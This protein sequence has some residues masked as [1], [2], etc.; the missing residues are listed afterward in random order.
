M[1]KEAH[2]DGKAHVEKPF[3]REH[4][5]VGATRGAGA[6]PIFATS[7]GGALSSAGGAI[8]QA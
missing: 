7:G 4:E 8:V 6:S 2:V 5:V 3:L 1:V